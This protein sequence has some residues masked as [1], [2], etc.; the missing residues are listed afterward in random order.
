MHDWFDAPGNLGLV[1]ILDSDKKVNP[2]TC[3]V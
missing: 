1:H 2:E 3:R